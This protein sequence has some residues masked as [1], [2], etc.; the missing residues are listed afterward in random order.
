M[1]FLKK[2]NENVLEST[3]IYDAQFVKFLLGEVFDKNI[4]KNTH[5][6]M[7]SK[8]KMKFARGIAFIKKNVKKYIKAVFLFFADIFQN[9]VKNDEFRMSRFDIYLRDYRETLCNIQSTST[10]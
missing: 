3:I 2:W 4:L 8:P 10:K 7:L 1:M 6:D 5:P 9:R